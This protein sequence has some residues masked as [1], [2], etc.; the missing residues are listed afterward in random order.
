MQQNNSRQPGK[1]KKTV[2][3]DMT[4]AHLQPQAIEA[5]KAVLGALMIDKNAFGIVGD[6]IKPES[7]YEPRNQM[8]YEAM[9][10]L[11]FEGAPVD[12][13]TVTDKMGKLGKLDEIGGPGYI[14]ELSSGVATSANIESHANIVAQ[15]ALARNLISLIGAAQTKAFDETNDIED[16]IQEAEQALFS[17]GE[18]SGRNTCESMD[19]IMAAVDSQLHLNASGNGMTGIPTGYTKFDEITSGLQPTDLIIIAGRPA[20][21][22]TAL[23]VSIIKNTAI[24]RNIPVGF[25]SMEMSNVQDGNR[26]MSN[27]CSIEGN[28]FMN[29]QLDPSDWLRYDKKLSVVKN[30]PLYVDDAPNMSIFELKTKARRMVREHNIKLLIVDYLQLMSAS[31]IRYGNRQ[32]EVATISRA[33]KG[34]AKE[35][36]IPVVALSQLNRGVESRDGLEG[37]RPQ[38]SDLRESGAIEQDADVVIFVHR[39]EYYH[40]YNDDKGNDLHGKAQIIIAKHRKGAVDDVLLNFKGQFTRFEDPDAEKNAPFLG[41]KDIFGSSLET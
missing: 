12:L 14:V 34:L 38:L 17:L 31:G 22:K 28:K 27:V 6:I 13:L 40:I 18:K 26:L 11:V 3:V 41:E 24:D 33:L 4:Y 29:G 8:I 20:M 5:E 36:N 23:A 9:C 21:G 19:S 10:E 30:K 37:K 2:Q 7:F 35:L 25:M 32:E 15:K 16:V 39:P 1:G